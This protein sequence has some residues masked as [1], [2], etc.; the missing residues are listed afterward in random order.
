MPVGSL[1]PPK[2]GSLFYVFLC[3][4]S[5]AFYMFLVI[6]CLFW[7]DVNLFLDIWCLFLVILRLFVV[8][9]CESLLGLFVHSKIK[10]QI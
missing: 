1:V 3:L 4:S 5:S 9:R 6:L 2:G 8:S 10:P 7:I